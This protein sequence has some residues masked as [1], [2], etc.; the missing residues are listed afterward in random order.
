MFK[1]NADDVIQFLVENNRIKTELGKNMFY[2]PDGSVQKEALYIQFEVRVRD[3]QYKGNRAARD[4]EISCPV[5]MIFFGNTSVFFHADK[6]RKCYGI[7]AP[8]LFVNTS[9]HD[10][11]WRSDGFRKL[12]ELYFAMCEEINPKIAP[13]KLD[14]YV[15]FSFSSMKKINVTYAAA[16]D[17]GYNLWTITKKEDE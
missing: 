3:F 7:P 1:A 17:Y 16:S 4:V 11:C 15:N 13:I 10:S 5:H 6:D 12:H 14:S 2:C 8:E 9:N